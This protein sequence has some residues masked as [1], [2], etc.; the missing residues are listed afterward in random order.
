MRSERS[1][2]KGG[3]SLIKDIKIGAFSVITRK[4]LGILSLKCWY[5]N[6]A[7]N[8]AEDYEETKEANLFMAHMAQMK[9]QTVHG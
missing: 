9:Q 5:K 2:Y 8:M 1:I 4:Y 3:S 6:K 7:I